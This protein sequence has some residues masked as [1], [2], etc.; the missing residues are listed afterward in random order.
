MKDQFLDI[1]ELR[2][3]LE[4]IIEYEKKLEDSLG[5][6]PKILNKY[7]VPRFYT[8]DFECVFDKFYEL[9]YNTMLMKE[10]GII[11]ESN[12]NEGITGVFMDKLKFMK[13]YQHLS[14]Q[15]IFLEYF[16]LAEQGKIEI[17][18]GPM[19]GYVNEDGSPY[20]DF[21]VESVE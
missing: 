1:D 9:F 15:A 5:G 20:E 8:E 21:L 4:S 7:P 19:K 11:V 18:Y 13:L 2:T 17:L 14:H 12:E 3:Q 6:R 10:L 16:R